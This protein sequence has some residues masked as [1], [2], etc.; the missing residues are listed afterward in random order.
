MKDAGIDIAIEGMTCAACVSRVERALTDVPGVV[1]AE[2][3]LAT[4]SARIRTDGTPPAEALTAAV[5][6]IGYG[7]SVIAATDA[8][9]Q[10]RR[11]EARERKARIA[12]IAG[13]AG[14]APFLIAMAAMP[15]GADLSPSPLV[16]AGLAGVLQFVLGARFYVGAWKSLRSRSAGM[17]LLV[18]LGTTAAYGLSLH[19]WREA[20]THGHAPHL[21]FESSSVVIAFVLLGKWLEER[22][23]SKSP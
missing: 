5:E 10:E 21:Y 14:A 3:N 19:L 12:A 8:G 1:T 18:A 9:A 7:A 16:Q 15:F 17:D 22:A 13:L 4:K 20:A 23:T 6:E 2:V 11:A